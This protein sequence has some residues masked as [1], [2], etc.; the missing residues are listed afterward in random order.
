MDS[1]ATKVK[2]PSPSTFIPAPSNVE[3]E[4]SNLT[5]P[6]TIPEVTVR[7]PAFKVIS[8][9]MST[10]P[11]VGLAVTFSTISSA[12]LTISKTL[13]L[14]IWIPKLSPTLVKPET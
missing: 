13:P 9:G 1:V 5:E 3:L 14:S 10:A 6:L 4:V 11:A 8:A 7:S 2:V 12:T